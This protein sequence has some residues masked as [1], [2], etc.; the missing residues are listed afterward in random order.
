MGTIDQRHIEMLLSRGASA[1]TTK[2][3]GDMLEDLICYLFERIPGIAVSKRNKR[4]VFDTE[5]IDVAFFNDRVPGGLPFLPWIILVECKNWSSP[6][7][8]DHVSWFYTKICSRGAEFGILFATNGI[9][10]NPALL[11]DAHS[12]IATALRERRHLIV[13]TI[14]VGR[15]NRLICLDYF[16]DLSLGF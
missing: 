3:K 8:S 13:I 7:G 16:L 9:T 15:L 4:N 1:Q 6:V 10:G 14:E 5:E 12:I 11:T 2:E